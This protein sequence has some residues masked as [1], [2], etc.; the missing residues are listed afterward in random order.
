MM[1]G[2][3]VNFPSEGHSMIDEREQQIQDQQIREQQQIQKDLLWDYQQTELKLDAF[4]AEFRKASDLYAGMS[5]TF[6]NDP[7]SFEPDLQVMGA[8]L[9]KASR[10]GQ[11]NTARC[12]SRM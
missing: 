12:R 5:M 9:E 3:I 2:T 1:F 8:E 4:R 11:K 6:R 7:S 10:N